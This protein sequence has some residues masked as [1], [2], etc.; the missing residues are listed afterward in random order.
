MKYLKSY[1]I[2]EN[3]ESDLSSDIEDV[4]LELKDIGFNVIVKTPPPKI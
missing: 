1:H 2:F 4:F 3:K